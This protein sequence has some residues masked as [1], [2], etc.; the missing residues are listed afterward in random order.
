M[1]F[2]LSA[3][4]V[5]IVPANDVAANGRNVEDFSTLT[6]C[7]VPSTTAWWDT[8][9]GILRLHP[10][11]PTLAG[12]YDTPGSA[13]HVVV[14]GDYAYVADG[15][16]GMHVFDVSDPTNPTLAGGYDT[17]GWCRSLAVAGNYVYVA[18]GTG[19]KLQVIDIS[20]P[21]SPTLAGSYMALDNPYWV[22]L[23][24]N[25]AYV[26]DPFLEPVYGIIVLDVTDPTNPVH[27]G[28]HYT[29]GFDRSAVVAGD[30]LYVA[31][32]V[33]GLYVFDITNPDSLVRVDQLN[34]HNARH[35]AI[36]AHYAYLADMEAGFRV[37]DVE[38]PSSPTVVRTVDT[39]G[40]AVGVHVDGN[41][42]YVA[43]WDEGMHV[44]DVSDPANPVLEHSYNTPGGCGKIDV[45][46]EHVFVADGEEGF[47]VLN[48][49]DQVGPTAVGSYDT[50]GTAINLAVAGHYAYVADVAEGLH[51]I[52]IA[53]PFTPTL[54]ATY[55][56]P[57][58]I[59]DVVIVGNY[60]FIANHWDGLTVVDVG[61][62]TNPTQLG[63]VDVWPANVSVAVEGDYAYTGADQGYFTYDVTDI[64]A[65]EQVRRTA[66]I[67]IAA[68]DT[69][70]DGNYTYAALPAHGLCSWDIRNASW[71]DLVDVYTTGNTTDVEVAGD[72]VYVTDHNNGFYA[73]DVTVPTAIA[74][75]A[76][77]ATPGHARGLSVSGD[78]AFVADDASGLQVIDISDPSNPTL[79]KSVDTPGLAC[80]VEVA[81]DYAYVAD[82]DAGLQV[83]QVF[84]RAVDRSRNVATSLAIPQSEEV[85]E[86]M[87][88]SDQVGSFRWFASTNGFLWD[89]IPIDDQFHQL[90]LP[91]F[92]LYWSAEIAYEGGPL[93][94]CDEVIID[95]E[96][97]NYVAITGFTA[98]S[99]ESGVELAWELV[100]DE[101]IDGFRVYRGTVGAGQ[102]VLIN[103]EG[104]IDPERRS[105]RDT[106]AD[107]Y[108]SH[109]YTLAVVK[110]DG[111]ESRSRVVTTEPLARKF[112]LD[113]NSPNPFNPRT[114]IRFSLD[115][116]A[117]VTL[118]IYDVSG[119]HVRTL[120]NRPM[121]PGLHV[122]EWDGRDAS[123]KS[124]PS[125]VYFY[126]LKA[127]KRTLTKKMLMV[128]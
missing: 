101:A 11:A 121:A 32:D 28:D 48:V 55:D 70:V 30:H 68:H 2:L 115:S 89:E 112:A 86:V 42:L 17:P 79:L 104:L 37:L 114:R 13:A 46:G 105:Y 82:Y 65:M 25:Y 29:A 35:V 113:Q 34:V 90:T 18:D 33:N 120:L 38:N 59:H 56:T 47:L 102:N 31:G 124:A 88:T 14:V 108:L 110:P 117:P 98:H 75:I 78:F 12:R 128:K 126:R 111:S 127:G 40:T 44:Y 96:Y 50:P 100:A 54:V 39:P 3:L 27:L 118:A 24:G 6:Y 53:D 69:K 61:D 9:S 109:R 87:I 10:F 95:R 20:D 62:P 4:I 66:T 74:Y 73:L 81:G 84:Q 43:D 21:T 83:I 123:G 63:R 64:T 52:D 45:A 60:A 97:Y 49:C 76:H 5:W 15:E 103:T 85:T 8:D 119:G 122:E 92:D 99:V 22:T 16:S 91:G 7:N 72:V 106:D 116:N 23:H 80:K 41:H 1:L 57:G 125:G 36:S 19:G 51:I 107:P 77:V 93:P 67:G 58:E 94:A 71:P 26:L